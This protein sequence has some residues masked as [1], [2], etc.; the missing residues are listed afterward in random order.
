MASFRSEFSKRAV[1]FAGSDIIPRN[2]MSNGRDSAG[3]SVTPD[4]A[5]RMS[6]VY[7]CVRLRSDAVSSLPLSAYVRRGRN[8][9]AYASV[10]GSQ[11]AWI[12][13]PNPE[14][15][16]LEFFEQVVS[17][18]DIHGNA[19]V[20]TVRDE[21]GEVVELWP[22]HPDDV[23]ISRSAE[24]GALVYRV[25]GANKSF[26]DL[27][28]KDILHVPT[29]KQLGSFYGL[30]PIGAARTALGKAM[31]IDNYAASYFK[32]AANPGGVIQTPATMNAEQIKEMADGWKADHQGSSKAGA[33]GIITGGAE[34]K[35]L[36][37]NAQDSQ[38]LE[39][40]KF[41]VEDIA[42]LFRV[43]LTL[44]G[45]PVA[46]AMSYASVEAN[47]LA[48]VQHTLRP[49]LERLEQAF[50]Q[51]L[52]E[53]DGFVK[54][55]LDALLRGTTSERYDNYAKGLQSGFLS[56]NDIRAT[57]DQS[58]IGSDGDSYRVPLQNIDASDAKKVGLEYVSKIAANL[59][60]VGF[61]PAA[62]LKAIGMEPIE[63]TGVMPVAVQ[64][65]VPPSEPVIRS[66]DRE[67]SNTSFNV[68]APSVTVEQP[69]IRV[70]APNVNVEA[71]NV[72][73]EAPAVTIN[74][75]TPRSLIKRT[76][77]RDESGRVESMTEEIITEGD[78]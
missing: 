7:A 69:E 2:S 28:S 58:S 27:S 71:P 43:P 32:N 17:S 66:M 29:F 15:T 6:T 5:L 62:V 68:D 57:E 34:F 55:N 77:Q 36:S 39:S 67:I 54:F 48:F 61:E 22:L 8:R 10:Y 4:S 9:L 50:S 52:P 47:N 76:V 25:R 49:I 53:S 59:I 26:K 3:V 21:M 33:V 74:N 19:Y 14:M 46:G 24:N 42:R 63:H 70:D 41:S 1:S 23:Q 37:I 16:R 65:V 51:L 35:P 44:L 11:P 73:V 31:A 38:M 40:Q 72:S 45:H 18:G 12:N 78:N 75:I 60:D 13:K 30:S 20:L 56:L 64:Q